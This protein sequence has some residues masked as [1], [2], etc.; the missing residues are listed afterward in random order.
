MTLSWKKIKEKVLSEAIN[1]EKKYVQRKVDVKCKTVII[2]DDG[3][4]TGY[5][6]MVAGKYVKNQGASRVIL[7][8]PVCPTDSYQRVHQYFDEVLCYQK[9]GSSFF[10]VGAYYQNFHQVKDED[11]LNII[12][13]AKEKWLYL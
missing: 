10:A 4:A 2:V 13:T 12:Q 11:L 3:M 6:A 5:T 7:A 1:K 8:V 9:V